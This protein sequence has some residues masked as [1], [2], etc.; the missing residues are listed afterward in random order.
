M[1]QKN[2]KN[3]NSDMAEN[4]NFSS[5]YLDLQSVVQ[6]LDE[7]KFQLILEE[8]KTSEERL[9]L[10]DKAFLD[11]YLKLLISLRN[12]DSLELVLR[13]GRKGRELSNDLDY[14]EEKIIK[15]Y[16]NKQLNDKLDLLRK[17]ENTFELNLKSSGFNLLNKLKEKLED[18]DHWINWRIQELSFKHTDALRRNQ[19]NAYSNLQ[20]LSKYFNQLG[21][22][23]IE[24]IERVKLD[25]EVSQLGKF[26]YNFK[27]ERYSLL[28]EL[29]HRLAEIRLIKS[30]L[31]KRNENPVDTE[32]DKHQASLFILGV[33]ELIQIFFENEFQLMDFYKVKIREILNE[34]FLDVFQFSFQMDKNYPNA[35]T[36]YDAFIYENLRCF[37]LVINQKFEI[38][39]NSAPEVIFEPPINEITI[40]LA[41]LKVI[42]KICRFSEMPQDILENDYQ[43]LLSELKR[44]MKKDFIQELTSENKNILWAILVVTIQIVGFEN[45]RPP[46][47]FNTIRI[48]LKETRFEELVYEI[49]FDETKWNSKLSIFESCLIK[50]KRIQNQMYIS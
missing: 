14:L 37:A 27:S 29:D 16:P 48:A 6:K 21:Y 46:G 12:G 28:C 17:A 22:E 34:L 45:K 49:K 44:I 13:H 26:I 43:G 40:R 47:N 19:L 42:E 4:V 25:Y 36:Y 50:L 2:S 5:R 15:C 7:G 38:D 1:R 10:E 11:N 20:I 24:E 18:G 32:L 39:I 35:K 33:F 9:K 3:G 23:N 30:R 41:I 8:M 31:F